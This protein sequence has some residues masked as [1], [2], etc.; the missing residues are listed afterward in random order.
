MILNPFKTINQPT[1]D[2]ATFKTLRDKAVLELEIREKSIKEELLSKIQEIQ[3]Q[4]ASEMEIIDSEFR[5]LGIIRSKGDKKRKA[6]TVYNKVTD[7]EIK[8]KLTTILSN[9]KKVTSSLI[10]KEVEISR[11][12]FNDFLKA[13]TGFIRSEGNRRSTVYFLS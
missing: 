6:R 5:E 10:F 1:S 12:R 13:N 3:M 2:Y 7:D 4:L 11:V 8:D 9:G